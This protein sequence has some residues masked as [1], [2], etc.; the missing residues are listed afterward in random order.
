VVD[1]LEDG[2]VP[3]QYHVDVVYVRDLQAVDGHV[4]HVCLVGVVRE[5]V[6]AAWSGKRVSIS[7][8]DIFFNKFSNRIFE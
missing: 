1:G 3:Q 4:V 8:N 7:E 2:P 6:R 5:Y